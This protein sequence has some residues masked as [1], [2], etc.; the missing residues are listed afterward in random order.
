MSRLGKKPI[1]VPANVTVE[2]SKAKTKIS[3]GSNTL[4]LELRPEVNVEFDS[5][6]KEIRVTIDP[7]DESNRQVRAYWGMTRSLLANMVEGVTKGYERSLEVV[8][9]GYTAVVAGK[10]LDLKLGTANTVK[11]PIP[12]GVD[13]QVERNF[14][15]L[16]GIDKQRVNQFAAEIRSTRKPEPYNGKGVRYTDEVVRR[17]Q[18]KV[19]A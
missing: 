18:G 1:P 19:G 17:K 13:V 16:K 9:V 11:L 8:G 5:G 6:E 10:T 14:I 2:V 15:R 4:E 3:A 7:A 12:M